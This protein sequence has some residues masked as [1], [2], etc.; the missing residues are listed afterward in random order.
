MHIY[1]HSTFIRSGTFLSYNTMKRSKDYIK[2]SKDYI[3]H[4]WA[5]ERIYVLYVHTVLYM[6]L[7]NTVCIHT[8][9]Y[10]EYISIYGYTDHHLFLQIK[11]WSLFVWA[12]LTLTC[13]VGRLET[14]NTGSGGKLKQGKENPASDLDNMIAFWNFCPKKHIHLY[15]V[16]TSDTFL[17]EPIEFESG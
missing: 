10:C 4:I 6:Y 12:V 7:Y 11:D 1:Y 17:W 2:R 5:S 15:V 9:T 3:T 16:V 13:L 8:Y 14:D